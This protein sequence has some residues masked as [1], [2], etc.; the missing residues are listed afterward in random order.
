MDKVIK[1]LHD[2]GIVPVIAIDD[3]DKAVP[4][5]KALSEGGLP[6]AEV[7][8]RTAAGEEAIRRIAKEVPEM[9]VGAGT[10]LTKEQADRAIDA[11]SKFIVSPGFNPEV[12]KYVISKG[13]PM[14]PGTATPGEMEQA[15][16]L[17][18]DT[19]KFF[20]AEQNGGIG[21]LKALAGPYKNLNWMPTG[22][23]NTQ[24]L[25]QYASFDQIVAVGGTWMVKKELINE[26]KWDEITEICKAAVKN[27]L[28][29]KIIHLGINESD[30]A[31][32]E[33]TAKLLCDLFGFDYKPGNSSV[34]AGADFEVMRSKGRGEHGHIAIGTYN[35]DR[36]IYHLGRK[37]VGFDESTRGTDAKGNTQNI[38]TDLDIAGFALHLKKI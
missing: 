11:G 8:F 21:K 31:S 4:L 29:F 2:I 13:V 24:N 12:T 28:G 33:K 27:L 9:L 32:A 25:A 15:M 3:A 38:Y 36:A 35:V 6:A 7:T 23:I 30:S 16:S 34:F 20:P 17:G 37:G 1:Q 14:C 5:A 26:E 10:V 19:V 18:L 22:G